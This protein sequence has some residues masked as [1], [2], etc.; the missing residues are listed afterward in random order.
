MRES[1]GDGRVLEEDDEEMVTRKRTG[2]ETK[3]SERKEEFKEV[4]Q[5]L[6]RRHGSE[7]SWSQLRLWARMFIAKTHDDL[8][9]P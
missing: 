6:K 1:V 9:H 4:F 8:D 2:R 3:R 5:Q 7:Y